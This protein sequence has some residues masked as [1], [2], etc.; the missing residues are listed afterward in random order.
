MLPE[1]D[2]FDPQ[3][4]E[5]LRRLEEDEE[6]RRRVRREIL[7]VQSGDADEEIERDREQERLEREQADEER[8]RQ[9]R[10]RSRL[11]WLLFSG[12][13]LVNRN[14]TE[15]YRYF[16]AIAAMCFVSI[17][18]MFTALH[19]DLKYSRMEREVQLLRE[20]SIRLQEQLHR[21]TTHAAIV[22][23]LRRRGIDLQDPRKP[24]AV[25][26]D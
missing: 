25:V 14:V 16:A 12:N 3:S 6:F 23:E 9:T 24:K 20:R 19:A 22:D 11:L 2:D 10:K 15:N 18:V 1:N 17:A 13:I 26:E 21:R 7:R 5:D 4:E 8:Q